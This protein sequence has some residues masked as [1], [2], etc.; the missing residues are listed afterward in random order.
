MITTRD[1][2]PKNG[3]KIIAVKTSKHCNP[4]ILKILSPET[5]YYF[6]NNYKIDPLTEGISSSATE[7]YNLYN[8]SHLE[9]NISA[10]V[11]KNG[12]GKSAI[13]EL[14][15]RAI[16][17]ICCKQSLKKIKFT[18]I[19]SLYLSMYY[20]FNDSY[21]MLEISGPD[22]FLTK[23]GVN[24]VPSKKSRKN[25]KL[26]AFFYTIAV[27]FS[28]YA[29]NSNDY[30][31]GEWIDSFFKTNDGYQMPMVINPF[32]KKGNIEINVEKDLLESRLLTN[33]IVTEN[34]NA[35]S[36]RRVTENLEA[37][38][39][40][41]TLKESKVDKELWRTEKKGKATIY[42]IKELI[43]QRDK[44]YKTIDRI[45]PFKN[46]HLDETYR[47]AKDY[48]LYKLVKICLNYPEYAEFF[49]KKEKQFHPELLDVFLEKLLKDHSHITFKL[50]QTLNFL[51]AQQYTLESQTILLADL[52]ENLKTARQKY[53]KGLN[54]TIEM[55]PPPLF[56]TEIIL[57]RTDDESDQEISV[58]SLSSGEKQLI[59]SVHSIIYHLIN[60]NSIGVNK[61]RLKYEHIFLVLEEIELYS[62]PD[63]Q[64][65][66]I[67]Y[68][69]DAVA[70]LP[71][72]QIKSIHVCFVTHSPFILSDIPREHILFLEENG[73]PVKEKESFLTFGAN[74]HD[75]LKQSF[76]LKKGAMGKYAM[77][78][79]TDAINYLNWRK[80]EKELK[81]LI[82]EKPEHLKDVISFKE[83]EIEAAKHEVIILD[84]E[85]H[86]KIIKLIDEPI[87]KRKLLQMYDELHESE[88]ELRLIESKV[89]LLLAQKATILARK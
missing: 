35:S 46:E 23:Y 48:I 45:F 83:R 72:D 40:K 60:V 49:S 9:I 34:H 26:G 66:Y 63:M 6:Y 56:Q 30:P 86:L 65:E 76:F 5:F 41:L 43:N 55:L 82:S 38:Q 57:R 64:K 70:K 89:E 79:I 11:G 12:S 44:I 81:H 52:Q 69:L 67:C 71:I 87:L 88:L 20:Y 42:T 25:P 13:I 27:N 78:K 73:Q 37:F 54:E 47:I 62:H 22:F 2:E 3:F 77:R 1:L 28:H 16:N 33:L 51:L 75:L 80:L 39:V 68:L 36:F 18:E 59:F 84:A 58:K 24:G 10:I 19:E 15:F 8:A 74:I 17:N 21:Y 32:R 31:E 61:G 7:S 50:K 85:E 14:I 53:S 4:S 29:Y